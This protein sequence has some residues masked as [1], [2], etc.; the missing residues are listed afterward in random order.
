MPPRLVVLSISKLSAEHI[1]DLLMVNRASTKE[2]TV[3]F[4]V[5][6]SRQPCPLSPDRRKVCTASTESRLGI[7][8][9]KGF[10]ADE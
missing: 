3:I 6:V 1:P 9:G 5:A 7:F 4:C 8:I 10:F 2:Y